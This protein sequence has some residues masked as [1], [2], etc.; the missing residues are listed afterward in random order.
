MKTPGIS[1]DFLIFFQELIDLDFDEKTALDS[2]YTVHKPFQPQCNYIYSQLNSGSNLFQIFNTS[3]SPFWELK[4]TITSLNLSQWLSYKISYINDSKDFASYIKKTLVG[5]ASLLIFSFILNVYLAIFFLPKITTLLSQFNTSIPIWISLIETSISYISLYIIP[6]LLIACCT[7]FLFK[8]Y[9]IKLIYFLTFNISREL[10]V[11]DLFSIITPYLNEGVD[12]KTVIKNISVT[13][14]TQ[15]QQTL[16]KFKTS[17]L[18]SAPYTTSFSKL[19]PNSA[20][21]QIITQAI[22]TNKLE[23]GLTKIVTLYRA[24]HK[25]KIKHLSSVVKIITFTLTGIN[26]L[27]GFYLTILPMNQIIDKLI[28]HQ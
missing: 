23:F 25:M 13:S 5:P 2:I 8:R 6:T 9:I 24:H 20:Y 28:T 19:I 12:F 26:I 17:I 11:I 4:C 18:N 22:A 7:V 14:S 1:L 10:F 3:L 21:I 15:L 27:I 16:D